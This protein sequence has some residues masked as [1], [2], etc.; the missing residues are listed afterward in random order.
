MDYSLIIALLAFFGA[1]QLCNKFNVGAVLCSA[2][3]VGIPFLVSIVLKSIYLIG[4]K[5]PLLENLFSVAALISIIC[6]FAAS[7]FIFR[8]LQSEDG[9]I[10]WLGWGVG[11]AIVVVVLIPTVI[12]AIELSF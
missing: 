7:V 8:K 9:Y 10:S 6:Q 12:R 2:V 4:Y 11:G 3:A 1:V 5:M